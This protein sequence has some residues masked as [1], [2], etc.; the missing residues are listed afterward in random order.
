MY[1]QPHGLEHGQPHADAG[2]GDQYQQPGADG[3][4]RERPDPGSA[5][6]SA[7]PDAEVGAIVAMTGTLEGLRGVSVRRTVSTALG[8]ADELRQLVSAAGDVAAVLR[9]VDALGEL[10]PSARD[11]ARG[12]VAGLYDLPPAAR[13]RVEAYLGARYGA[14]GALA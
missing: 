3:A 14:A 7:G 2:E 13:E 12:I 8:V 9:V 6:V 11:A 4:S 5:A 10:P 1:D